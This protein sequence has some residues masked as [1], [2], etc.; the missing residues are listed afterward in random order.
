MKTLNQNTDIASLAKEVIDKCKLIHPSKLL[1][2]E[3]LLYYLQNRKDNKI[4][5]SGDGKKKPLTDKLEDP[6]ID[7]I[8]E[9]ANINELDNYA[10]MLYEDDIAI[11]VR[12]SA[13]ILQLARNPDNL[14]ELFQNGIFFLIFF[15]SKFLKEL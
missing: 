13:L 1:E 3:Q 4:G 14:D 12:G 15:L 10:E 7:D 6:N 11:K 5:S 2:V 9:T 8:N